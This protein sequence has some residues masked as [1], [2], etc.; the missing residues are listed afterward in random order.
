MYIKPVFIFF[1]PFFWKV[2]DHLLA[3]NDYCTQETE[4]LGGLRDS[5][6]KE[7]LSHL[8]ETD[9]EVHAYFL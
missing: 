1:L 6:Y 9:G 5:L 4:H 8:K 3:E 2:V 7:M